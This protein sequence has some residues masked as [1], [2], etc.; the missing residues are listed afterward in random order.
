MKFT[1]EQEAAAAKA[2]LEI[3]AYVHHKQDEFANQMLRI[4][5]DGMLGLGLGRIAAELMRSA[6]EKVEPSDDYDHNDEVSL[7]LD[8]DVSIGY[9]FEKPYAKRN[10]GADITIPLW[11]TGT[12][13]LFE[14]YDGLGENAL[15]ECVN[16]Y[17]RQVELKE[18]ET[19]GTD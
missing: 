17:L 16:E 4:S 5:G 9:S 15:K 7:D 14:L 6:I 1:Q 12:V 10:T 3:W 8:I 18:A 19:N 11:R 2:S 13:N